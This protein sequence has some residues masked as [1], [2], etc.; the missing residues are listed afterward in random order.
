[1]LM[2]NPLHRLLD[3][4]VK[5]DTLRSLDRAFVHFLESLDPTADVLVL[6]L[7]AMVSRQL[8]SG[9]ICVDLVDLPLLFEDTR[10]VENRFVALTRPSLGQWQSLLAASPL[11]A[12]AAEAEVKA[13]TPLVLDGG[14]IY[15][16]RY[17][18][19]E[20]HVAQAID[21]RLNRTLPTPDGL[22]D[23]LRRL[24]PDPAAQGDVDWQKIACAIAARS[25]F[26]VIT[27]GPGTGK[28]TTVVRLLGLL[29]TLTLRQG[30]PRLRI[31]L[32][33]PTGKAA[34]RLNESIAAQIERLDVDDEVKRAI[35]AE[36]TTLHRLLGSRADTRHFRH[37][38]GNPLHV[39]VLVIDEASMVDLEMMAAVLD[40]L[41]DEARL[42]LIGDKDQLSSVE[43][44]AVLGDLCQR[45]DEGHYSATTAAWLGDADAGDIDAWVDGTD[46]RAL[47]QHIVML[48]RSHR[49]TADSGIGA[50]A[51][52][53][54][55]GAVPAVRRVLDRAGGYADLAFV[56]QR[57]AD[58]LASVAIEGGVN[59]FPG[60]RAG[61]V[62]VGYRYYLEQLRERRPAV[63]ASPEA[64]DAWARVV[65]D[66]FARF[67]L[68]CAVRKGEAGVEEINER[69]A[70]NL[71]DAGLVAAAHGWYEGRPVLVTRNDYSLGL[72]NGDIGI[73]LEVPDGQGGSN[74]RVAFLVAAD[75]RRAAG[76]TPAADGTRIRYVTP[77]RLSSVETVYAMTVHKSQ[78]SEFTHTALLLPEDMSPVL[79]RELLYTGITRA[80]QWFTLLATP[81]VLDAAVQRRTRRASGLRERF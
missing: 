30:L 72:M 77:S 81:D 9:H 5:E 44:G 35:P 53:V 28:T 19:Y 26:A 22:A 69:L 80:R 13:H 71:R 8:G 37:G 48:R 51:Q 45:A 78:G 62:P 64:V 10:G 60:H 2:D 59:L 34:A 36:V 55:A 40:A 47:D 33:A 61:A 43:A 75:D 76:S 7:A 67:Q 29:Q 38:R 18:A 32:A 70:E 16:R 49:F 63:D 6:L 1:M 74:L 14:R 52:A 21:L 27:G 46:A 68:L 39:D 4:A 50:L 24:F 23:E 58:T 11:V 66:A 20:R 25:A 3:E 42:I 31:R 65:L 79:T 41:P 15:L 56:A 73:A 54:N 57:R 12:S 17:W